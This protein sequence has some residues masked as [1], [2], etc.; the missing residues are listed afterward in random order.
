MEV[1]SADRCWID[2]QRTLGLQSSERE[3]ER[4]VEGGQGGQAGQT[5]SNNNNKTELS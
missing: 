3:R 4:A 2:R 5:G 1:L